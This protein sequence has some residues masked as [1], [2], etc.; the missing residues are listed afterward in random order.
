M[1]EKG[2]F[3]PLVSAAAGRSCGSTVEC[4]AIESFS[5][6]PRAGKLTFCGDGRSKL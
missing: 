3:E 4:Q 5:L 2:I 1:A 6:G